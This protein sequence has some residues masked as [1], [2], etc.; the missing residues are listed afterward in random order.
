MGAWKDAGDPGC[1]CILVST[2]F[3]VERWFSILLEQ[4]GHM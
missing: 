4:G 1:E 3:S 2:C